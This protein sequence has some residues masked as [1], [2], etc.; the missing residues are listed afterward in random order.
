M[1]L[2]CGGRGS[3]VA[4]CSCSD[5]LVPAP[6]LACRRRHLDY[7]KRNPGAGPYLAG[8]APGHCIAPARRGQSCCVAALLCRRLPMSTH[9]PTPL[10]SPCHRPSPT[11]TLPCA[12]AGRLTAGRR[13]QRPELPPP[14]CAA[15]PGDT[16]C[17]TTCLLNL[18][19][20]LYARL[21]WRPFCDPCTPACVP[22][23]PSALQ[24]TQPV[25]CTPARHHLPPALCFPTCQSFP[26]ARSPPLS[27]HLTP[28]K[29]A[30][31]CLHA[32]CPAHHQ[33]STWPPRAP[34]H[35]TGRRRWPAPACV[36]KG[37][38]CLQNGGRENVWGQEGG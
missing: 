10:P 22:S 28:V 15:L 32:P 21:L 24:T 34:G 35:T 4:G 29:Y 25:D 36:N 31:G 1:A 27:H 23:L 14:G 3:G 7:P 11:S 33:F 16:P 2:Q 37:R 6:P 9:L 13:P 8:A 20:P 5:L 26:Y 38:V 19:S 18:S 30:P 17:N 12:W